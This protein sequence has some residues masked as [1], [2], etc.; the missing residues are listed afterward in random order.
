MRHLHP[1]ESHLPDSSHLLLFFLGFLGGVA[2]DLVNSVLEL[3]V[4]IT[5]TTFVLLQQLIIFNV[6]SLLELCDPLM[7]VYP[8]LHV[9][10]SFFD[11]RLNE[12]HLLNVLN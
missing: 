10:L 1:F 3:V 9:I 6:L 12:I 7:V 11:D 8:C 2:R 5:V 4:R